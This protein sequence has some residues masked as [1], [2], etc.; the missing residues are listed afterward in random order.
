MGYLS[1]M[2]YSNLEAILQGSIASLSDKPYNIRM[3]ESLDSS[4]IAFRLQELRKARG[5]SS[6]AVSQRA[7][8]L[9]YQISHSH[10]LDM[11][12][13]DIANLTVPMLR[14]LAAV[15]EVPLEEILGEPI[16]INANQDD[17]RTEI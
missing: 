8:R 13:G 4:A 6:R 15:Y 9:G 3:A 2:S 17:W 10:V 14:I 7:E 16:P 11:E 5:F 1:M 12:K